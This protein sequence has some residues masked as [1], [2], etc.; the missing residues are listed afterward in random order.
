MV[1]RKKL[2]MNFLERVQIHLPELNSWN[3]DIREALKQGLRPQIL[4]VTY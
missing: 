1:A 3:T 2:L 4:E